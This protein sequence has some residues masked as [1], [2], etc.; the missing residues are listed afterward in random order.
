MKF[1]ISSGVSC[2]LQHCLWMLLYSSCQSVSLLLMYNWWVL[3]TLFCFQVIFMISLT[4]DFTTEIA[5]NEHCMVWWHVS[6]KIP[7]FKRKL[8]ARDV[9]ILTE[10]EFSHNPIAMRET[11]MMRMIFLLSMGLPLKKVLA[12]YHTFMQTV[13]L[14]FR[15][16]LHNVGTY[17][18]VSIAHLQ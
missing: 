14:Y 5:M 16:L 12:C 8:H 4:L 18:K 6:F 2:M 17:T 1:H 11:L 15:I 9:K 10:E 13:C 3:I 7:L